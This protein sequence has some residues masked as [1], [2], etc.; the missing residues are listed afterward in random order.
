MRDHGENGSRDILGVGG[1]IGTQFLLDPGEK[2]LAAPLLE[3]RAGGNPPL[4]IGTAQQH[5]QL[6]S[7]LGHFLDGVDDDPRAASK[8]Y[9]DGV[10]A[11]RRLLIEGLI[12]QAKA[13][14]L[15][16]IG[17]RFASERF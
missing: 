9:A 10:A 8:A 16:Q 2:L 12:G 1:R 14:L 15:R 3:R 4:V 17:K 5:G 13:L 11:A 7:E 6:R